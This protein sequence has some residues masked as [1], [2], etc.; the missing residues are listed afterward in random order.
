MPKLSLMLLVAAI[1]G[2]CSAQARPNILWI[3]SEDNGP[4]LGCYGDTYATTPNVDALAAR[5]L[6]YT[7]AWSNWPVCAPARTAIITG[8]YPSS[9]GSEHMRSLERL[10]EGMQFFPELLRA[11]GYYCTNNS[12]EDYN[13]ETPGRPWDES[14]AKA[15]WKNRAPDQPFFAVFN[16]MVSHESQLRSKRPL[17]HDPALVRVP[18][19]HPDT[20]EVRTDWARYYDNLTL[21]DAEL[22]A[23][24]K[25]IEEAGLAD[26]TIIVY[27]G[28]HGSGMPRHKRSA[29]DSGLRVPLIV[30]IPEKFAALAPEGYA[31][32][33]VSDRLVSFIDLAPTMLSLVGVA[34]P[35]YIQGRAF[36]GLA[37]QAPEDYLFGGRGRMDARIDFVRCARDAR[38]VYVRNYMP[39][40]PQGQHL[41]YQME[42]ATTHVWEQLYREGKLNPVQSYFWG[43]KAPEELYDLETDPYETVNLAT[44]PAQAETLKRFRE[45]L[46][47]KLIKIRDVDFMP[48][49]M[50]RALPDTTTPYAFG[51]DDAAYPLARILDT[52]QIAAM[53]RAD[54]TAELA[55]RTTDQNPVVRYWAALGIYMRGADAIATSKD[56]VRPLL[57]DFEPTVQIVA[58]QALA[59]HGDPADIAPAIERLLALADVRNNEITVV[60]FALNALDYLDDRAKPWLAQIKALPTDE[61][62]VS[63]RYRSYV[64]QLVKKILQDL[65]PAG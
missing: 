52:A 49:P 12:K 51:H 43:P 34:I 5:S 45:A 29:M 20:P 18:P 54:D 56:A 48:E 16:A 57:R 10:P 35:E 60:C 33:G 41:A 30:H 25:E 64:P 44:D 27:F 32:G 14:S 59:A 31:A 62:N 37:A 21:M 3:T 13:L 11:A 28:D 19:Y 23:R 36:E 9:T 53:L 17:V 42:T 2:L 22:G 15:H 7:R 46:D 26:D 58:A 55:R 50:L 47:A 65:E 38:F 39:H 6:R 61:S 24:L 63:E 1:P 4:N 40:L 8:M